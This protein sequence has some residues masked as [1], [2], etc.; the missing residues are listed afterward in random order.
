MNI[1]LLINWF[2]RCCNPVGLLSIL[3][4]PKGNIDLSI[5]AN[6]NGAFFFSQRK[7][8]VY[9]E[10]S[11]PPPPFQMLKISDHDTND[12]A[13]EVLISRVCTT[14]L[15]FIY[16]FIWNKIDK[17]K[18]CITLQFLI[19]WDFELAFIHHI[20]FFMMR[21]QHCSGSSLTHSRSKSSTLQL[22]NPNPGMLPPAPL[23]SKGQNTAIQ[24]DY[25]VLHFKLI[26]PVQI[27]QGNVYMVVCYHGTL[28]H[29]PNDLV[30]FFPWQ[31]FATW[32]TK[33]NPVQLVLCKC[34]LWKNKCAKVARFWGI[35]FSEIVI[36]R[37][38]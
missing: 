38:L 15:L 13:W 1:D 29:L 17:S 7:G 3:T 4:L 10:S 5:L 27:G 12:V 16:L 36:F 20:N 33:T 31:L 24:E 26:C 32:C 21:R 18:D 34:F 37:T 11:I 8:Q 25:W 14:W 28:P 9:N 22:W 35:F 19:S 23:S 2:P 6:D 30:L